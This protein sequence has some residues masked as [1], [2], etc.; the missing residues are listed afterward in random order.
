MVIEKV[1]GWWIGE[2]KTVK[3]IVDVMKELKEK[4]F[5]SIT[6][7]QYEDVDLEWEDEMEIEE[8]N[9][10]TSYNPAEAMSN[11]VTIEAI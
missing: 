9:L 3:E 6:T 2:L 1:L 7:F 8:D 5:L 11:N 4:E 10:L